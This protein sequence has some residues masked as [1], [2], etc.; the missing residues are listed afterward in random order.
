LCEKSGPLDCNRCFPDIAPQDFFMRQLFVQ[1]FFKLVDHFVSPSEFL[2]A[3]YVDWGLPST[4][5]AVVENGR[6]ER[7]RPKSAAASALRTRFVVLGQ[8]S[9]LKGTLVVLQAARLLPA[10][11]KETVRIEI[12]GSMQHEPESFKEQFQRELKDLEGVVSYGGPYRPDDVSEI[13]GQHGWVIQ[14]SIWWE[15]S[16]LVIQEAFAAGR[17]VICS[18]IGGMAEKVTPYVSGLHFRVGSASDL[19]SRLQEAAGEPGLWGRLR[20]G[21]P[22]PP[23]IETTVDALLGIYASDPRPQ[24]ALALPTLEASPASANMVR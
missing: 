3:R 17:P 22:A 11:L 12:H 20:R 7:E 9:R 15:N 14:P 5:I 19:C 16:P 8:L 23:S 18:N 24:S 1:S 21:V 10:A 6:S 13:I 2:K 4:Q